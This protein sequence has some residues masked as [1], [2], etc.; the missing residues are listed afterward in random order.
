MLDLYPAKRGQESTRSPHGHLTGSLQ[1]L[2]A[3]TILCLLLF[4]EVFTTRNLE[5]I[6]DIGSK[7]YTLSTTSFGV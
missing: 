6:S 5:F 2:L 1:E 4:I 7:E 3:P